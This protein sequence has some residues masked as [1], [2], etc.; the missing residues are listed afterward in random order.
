MKVRIERTR[1]AT[2]GDRKDYAYDGYVPVTDC[3][4]IEPHWT[5]TTILGDYKT[6]R[7]YRFDVATM[8]KEHWQMEKGWDRYEDYQRHEKLAKVKL[9]E[10]AR[11]VYP[12]LESVNEWPELWIEIPTMD[13]RHATK[14]TEIAA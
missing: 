7:Y 6:G 14:W 12:E 5:T 11:T 10:L 4:W 3:P 8:P 13:A 9:L 1:M 2:G